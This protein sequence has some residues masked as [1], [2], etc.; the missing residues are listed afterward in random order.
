[1]TVKVLFINCIDYFMADT[2]TMIFVFVM[3]IIRSRYFRI[4]VG[5]VWLRKIS[6]RNIKLAISAEF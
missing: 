1:M 2:L 3:K 6:K 4:V 5:F